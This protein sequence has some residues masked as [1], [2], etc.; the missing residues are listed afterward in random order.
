MCL[1]N[2]CADPEHQTEQQRPKRNAWNR[3][4]GVSASWGNLAIQFKKLGSGSWSTAV[5]HRRIQCYVFRLLI[6]ILFF[7]Y[8]PISV[9]CAQSNLSAL[10]LKVNQKFNTRW[11]TEEQLL[12]VQGAFTGF[13]FFT[14]TF[15]DLAYEF[16]HLAVEILR[17]RIVRRIYWC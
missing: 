4:R 1:W 8:F 2:L 13:F 17:R 14:C 12:A 15:W 3:G 7:S 5:A 10:L 6:L 11:T 9:F 16:L